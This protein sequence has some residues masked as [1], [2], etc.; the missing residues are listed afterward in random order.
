MN[1]GSITLRNTELRKTKIMCSVRSQ[2]YFILL[3]CMHVSGVS[4]NTGYEIR[5]ESMKGG[6]KKHRGREE[7]N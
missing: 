2:P 3:T 1:L 7:H 6:E 5:K 4:V